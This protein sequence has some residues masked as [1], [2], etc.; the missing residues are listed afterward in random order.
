M[1]TYQQWVVLLCSTCIFGFT[2]NAAQGAWWQQRAY[3]QRQQT[4]QQTQ[5]QNEMD[6]SDTERAPEAD[7]PPG[8]KRLGDIAY[9]P[10]PAQKMDVYLPLQAQAKAPFTSLPVIF[11]V[12]GGAWRFGDKAA[13]HVISNKVAHWLPHG[14]VFVSINYRMLPATPIAE[15]ARDVAKALAYAQARASSWG[16]DP[17]QLVLMGHSAGAHLVDLLSANPALAA[18]EGAKPWRATISLDSAAIDVAALMQRRHSKALYDAAF[19]QDPA[20]WAQVSPMQQLRAGTLP[21][22][23]VCSSTR[24]DQPCGPTG[25]FVEAAKKL[26]HPAQLLPVALSHE[27]INATLGQDNDYTHTVDAFIANLKLRQ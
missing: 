18:A 6:D 13:G 5:T 23:M 2:S 20:Y 16:A 24:R 4:Q 21:M 10:D 1:R 12:H 7:L 22:L 25:D 27:E 11:M 19:G 8:V 26:G 9:G 14:F 17:Q 3:A 15:Q